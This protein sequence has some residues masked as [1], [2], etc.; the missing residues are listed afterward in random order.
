[1]LRKLLKYEFQATGRIFLPLYGALII[2][3]IIQRVF[4]A[5]NLNNLDSFALNILTASVP[6]LFGAL[7]FGICVVTFI[8]MI[9]RFYKNLLG[10]EGY[11]MFTLP[12]S[13]AKLI[14]SKLIVIIVWTILSVIVGIIAFAIVF[15][16]A[17]SLGMAFAEIAKGLKILMTER[18]MGAAVETV[19]LVFAMIALSVL[20]IYLSMAI[21]QMASKHRILS[22]VGA[23]IGISFIINNVVLAIIVAMGNSGVIRSVYGALAINLD[24]IQAAHLLM[25][26]IILFFAAQAV[27]YF[28]L[29]RHILTKKLNLE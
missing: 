20:S 22:S 2:V 6:T 9:Q 17:Y 19:I 5:F 27:V 24:E 3:A 4:L 26:L 11:L 18:L 21:G 13:A 10:R 14:W 28:L 7:I 25:W 1:M 29:T 16:D 8:M 15:M 12:V 23:Y